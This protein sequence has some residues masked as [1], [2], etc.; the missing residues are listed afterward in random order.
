MKDASARMLNNKLLKGKLSLEDRGE[1]V[2]GDNG[3]AVDCSGQYIML[4]QMLHRLAGLG[5][6]G[7]LGYSLGS[8]FL[9]VLGLKIHEL[10]KIR[11]HLFLAALHPLP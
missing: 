4:H 6:L 2:G 9:L 1:T 3:T 7:W 8:S 10:P 5:L 11:V